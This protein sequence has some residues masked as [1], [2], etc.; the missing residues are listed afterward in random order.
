MI[1]YFYILIVIKL[2]WNK[3]IIKDEQLGSVAVDNIQ[4]YKTYKNLTH[5]ISFYSFP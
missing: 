2:Y 1:N 3:W 5:S 4:N